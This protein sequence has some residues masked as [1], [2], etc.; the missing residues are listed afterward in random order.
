[1]FK[2]MT[3]GRYRVW[4][5]QIFRALCVLFFSTGLMCG[6]FTRLSQPFAC[7]GIALFALVFVILMCLF[8]VT[9]E[10]TTHAIR[11]KIMAGYTRSEVFFSEMLINM[12]TSAIFFGLFI[13]GFAAVAGTLA[14]KE[15]P[16]DIL[17]FLIVLLLYY[18][19]Y[20]AIVTAIGMMCASGMT[21]VVVGLVLV[22][23]V[24]L[25][26]A[27]WSTGVSR[28]TLEIETQF[29]E[30]YMNIRNI[31]ETVSGG[32]PYITSVCSFLAGILI[33]QIFYMF[34]DIFKFLGIGTLGLLAIDGETILKMQMK[35]AIIVI[36]FFLLI[37]Y[38][39]FRKKEIR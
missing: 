10:F 8:N 19:E 2:L 22:F 5:K 14:I 25:W 12:E 31:N 36:A 11:N 16:G 3:A 15:N 21:K 7:A 26:L 9:T 23:L 18:M 17:L 32:N 4:T 35:Y 1:M 29:S 34:V 38:V 24:T 27:D 30:G 28:E 33:E 39:I 13:L 6:I 20:A 37:G